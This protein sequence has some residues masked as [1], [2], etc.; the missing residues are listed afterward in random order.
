MID[1]YLGSIDDGSMLELAVV[2]NDD[3][4]ILGLFDTSSSSSRL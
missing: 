4:S 2:G 3:G 1:Q